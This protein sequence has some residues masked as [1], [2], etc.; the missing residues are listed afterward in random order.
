MQAGD[1]AVMK[2]LVDMGANVNASGRRR[3][4]GFQPLDLALPLKKGC[5]SGDAGSE[6]KCDG[7]F[8][9]ELWSRSV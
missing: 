9:W 8:A 4:W 1:V 2:Y 7:R 5:N 6:V 3:T